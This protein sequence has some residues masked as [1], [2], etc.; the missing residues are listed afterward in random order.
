MCFTSDVVSTPDLALDRDAKH[1]G[2]PKPGRPDPDSR[3]P[4]TAAMPARHDHWIGGKAEPPARGAYLPTIDLTTRR[5]DDGI[6][7]GTEADAEL[8]ELVFHVAAYCGAPAGVAAGL[9]AV[10][11][12]RP[13][14]GE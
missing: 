13:G 10:R 1:P 3:T 5:P 12:E 2:P 4:D 8:D 9:R 6:A 7:A 14:P 11:A